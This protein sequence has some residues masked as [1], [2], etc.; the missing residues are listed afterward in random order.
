MPY[1]IYDMH[2]SF[3]TGTNL[4]QAYK[5]HQRQCSSEVCRYRT[6]NN[7]S[8]V[9]TVALIFKVSQADIN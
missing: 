8:V 3:S 7:R 5:T 6:A 1:H 2:T 4:F 9:V